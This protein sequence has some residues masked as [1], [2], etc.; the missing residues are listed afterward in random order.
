MP[1]RWLQIFMMFF[2][3]SMVVASTTTLHA[4]DNLHHQIIIAA[5]QRDASAKIFDRVLAGGQQKYQRQALLALGRIGDPART[6]E[7]ASFL[8]SKQPEIR[9]MAAFAL[10]I[11][12]DPSAHKLLVAASKVEVNTPVL[13]ELLRAIGSLAEAEGAISS[14]LPFLNHKNNEVVAAACDGLTLAWTFHRDRVSIPN[15]TQIHRLIELSSRDDQIAQHCLYTV[16]RLRSEPKLFNLQQLLDATK[17][18]KSTTSKMIS[19][20]TMGAMSDKIFSETFIEYAQ[21]NQPIELRIEAAAAI[22]QL[23]Y[24]P[25]YLKT[26]KILAADSSSHVRVSLI[27]QLMLEKNDD[28][29]SIAMNLLESDSQWVQHRSALALF[30]IK[31]D[32]I[33]PIFIKAL[34][35]G[36]FLQQQ[37]ALNILR[38]HEVTDRKKHLAV[39]TN[40]THKGIKSIAHRVLNDE[41]ADSEE[42]SPPNNSV[43]PLKALGFAN[44]RLV[45]NTTKGP[46]TIQLTT[47]AAYTSAAFYQLAMSGFYDGLIFHRVVPNFV[48]QGG[49]PERTGQGGPG[50]SIREELYP[51][52]HERGTVGIATSGKDTGGSQFFFNISDNLHLNSHYTIFARIVDGIEIITD[53]EVGDSILSIK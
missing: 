35:S 53:L 49:D 33:M 17:H 48:V 6:I 12:G 26:I 52:S 20:R 2:L 10:G 28:L 29:L 25:E 22:A 30:P 40:S 4:E 8:Y 34:H 51:M 9:I 32:F 23:D 14:L 31:T 41:D 3:F 42:Y 7:I 43:T 11:N 21:P 27:D 1:V 16:S 13:T 50:Y 44:K 39:L 36:E 45:I 5:D 24:Q 38:T 47:A 46:I 37:F 18:F 15:S 19:L